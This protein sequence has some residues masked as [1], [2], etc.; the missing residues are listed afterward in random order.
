MGFVNFSVALYKVFIKKT[1]IWMLKS[2]LC[3]HLWKLICWHVHH[4]ISQGHCLLQKE[5]DL[6]WSDLNKI[7]KIYS[8]VINLLISLIWLPWCQSYCGMQIGFPGGII[9]PERWFFLIIYWKVWHLFLDF[10]RIFLSLWLFK[11]LLYYF[12]LHHV[13]WRSLTLWLHG[14]PLPPNPRFA[15][16]QWAVLTHSEL[17]FLIHH[18]ELLD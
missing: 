7:G 10:I 17:W 3:L 5:L 9:I 16:W 6:L 2:L 12:L 8:R 11:I 1:K 14:S 13:W 15:T 18:L 4:L